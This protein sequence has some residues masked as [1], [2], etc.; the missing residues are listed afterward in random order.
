MMVS[1]SFVLSVQK[2]LY[3]EIECADSRADTCTIQ[4]V[5]IGTTEVWIPKRVN[6][7]N[8]RI[9]EVQEQ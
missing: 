6:F 7:R 4:P 8:A 2:T 5:G 1:R 9:V 3:L